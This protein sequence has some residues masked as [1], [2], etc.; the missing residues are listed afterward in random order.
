MAF[1]REDDSTLADP[2]SRNDPPPSS[3]PWYVIRPESAVSPLPSMHDPRPPPERASKCLSYAALP[4]Q[5][6]KLA[7]SR[8]CGCSTEQHPHPSR[9][10]PAPA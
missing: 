10:P 8:P 6:N 5:P 3:A 9:R 1:I 4:L 7:V 2:D